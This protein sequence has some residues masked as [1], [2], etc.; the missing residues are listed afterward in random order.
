MI[1]R[2]I[3]L[4]ALVAVAGYTS[5]PPAPTVDR[6]TTSA[7]RPA[8]PAAVPGGPG[9]YTVKRGDTLQSVARRF[10]V[11]HKDILRWNAGIS[12]NLKPGQQLIIQIPS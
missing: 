5:Q 2:F 12:A 10:K 9:Y 1:F 3:P 7:P 4:V 8:A 6:S 11:D